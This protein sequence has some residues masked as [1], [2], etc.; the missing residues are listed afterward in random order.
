M[1]SSSSASE[2]IL[3][4]PHHG[5]CIGFFEGRGYSAEFV[6]HMTEVIAVLEAEDP[7]ITLVTH[8]DA[9]C[10]A[11]PHNHGGVCA[12]ADKVSDYDSGVLSLCGLHAGSVLR[13]SA[14]RETVCAQILR[15]HL[16]HKVCGGCQWEAVCT[17]KEDA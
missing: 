5:L 15:K 6:R 4:R 13:W 2:R 17:A 8:C 1:S 9:L 16:L 10:A 7:E 11:C 12:R 14:F 3:L